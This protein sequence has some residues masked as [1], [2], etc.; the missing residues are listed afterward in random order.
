[1]P[2]PDLVDNVLPPGRHCCTEDELHSRFVDHGDFATSTT[3]RDIWSQWGLA[4]D[5]LRSSVLVH[6][7]WVSGS[8]LTTKVSPNDIDVTFII[9]EADRLRRPVA[10]LQMVEAFQLRKQDQTTG[11]LVPAHGLARVDTYLLGWAPHHLG[12]SGQ[13][14]PNYSAYAMQ[15]G[16]WDDWWSRRRTTSKSAPLVPADAY[17]RRGYLEVSFDDYT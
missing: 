8:F 11:D 16:Y 12:P 7:A 5:L 3:R 4:R 13:P 14:D 15:R 10:D 6:R 1:M 17:P 2:I 9:N